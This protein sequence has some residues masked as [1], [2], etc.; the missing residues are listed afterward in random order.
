MPTTLYGVNPEHAILLAAWYRHPG[1]GI[2]RGNPNIQQQREF[3]MRRPNILY[4]FG[5][6]W[7]AQAHGYMGNPN[8]QTPHIDGFASESINFINTVS[9]C[10]VCTPYRGSLMTGQHPHKHGLVVND[11]C[12]FD[13]ASGPFLAEVFRDHGYQTAYFGKWHIDGR[14]RKERV[15]PERHLGFSTWIGYECHHAYNDGWYYRHDTEERFTYGDYD[16]ADQT[17]QACDFLQQHDQTGAPFFL[18][19]SW[20]PPHN[21]YHNAPQR[22]RDLYSPDQIE[23]RPNVPPEEAEQARHDLAGYY[24]HCTALDDLFG[25]LLETLQATGLAESTIVVYTSDHGDMLGSQGQKRKQR[26]WDESCR[27]PLLVRDPR[28]PSPCTDDT[29]INTPDLMPTLCGLAGLPIPDSVQGKDFSPIIRDGQ[30]VENEAAMLMLYAPFHE[31][32]SERGGR[33]YRGLRSRRYTYVRCLD[34][35]PWLLYDNQHDPYQLIN[36]IDDPAHAEARERLDALLSRRLAEVEDPLLSKDE[37]FEQ[38]DIKL[39]DQGDVAYV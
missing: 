38:Y 1:S 28:R 18:M 10:P 25:Q 6:Q 14:G 11:Q 12:L 30:P 36:V 13:R 34:T 27:V 24:A 3:E 33:N 21:P 37:L 15:P 32:S 7:R 29:P 8:V 9:G 5:D 20:G 39:N 31:W 17:D 4:V 26:P 22:Y 19:L 35:G 23:L 2:V 16:A